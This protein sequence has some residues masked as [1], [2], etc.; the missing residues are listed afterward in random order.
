MSEAS[1]AGGNT[2]RLPW[3]GHP[4]PNGLSF[5]FPPPS[6]GVTF[7]RVMIGTQRERWHVTSARPPG[8]MAG[9]S[10]V[11]RVSLPLNRPSRYRPPAQTP[12]WREAPTHVLLGDPTGSG[13]FP[14]LSPG[15]AFPGVHPILLSCLAEKY[16]HLQ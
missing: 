10:V 5:H 15:V 4:L 12:S 8:L 16:S 11:M 3:V 6:A 1:L 14:F 13:I 7:C 2:Q 9:L